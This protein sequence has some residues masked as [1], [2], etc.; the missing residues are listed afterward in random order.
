MTMHATLITLGDPERL[1]GGYLYHRRVAELAARF[2]ASLA[3]ATVPDG[4]LRSAAAARGTLRRAALLADVLVCDSIVAAPLSLAINGSG[5]PVVGML[6]Q[7]PGGIDGSGPRRLLQR[8]FDRAAYRRMVHLIVASEQLRRCLIE[9]GFPDDRITVAAPGCDPP[10][11]MGV[12]AVGDLR[13]GSRVAFLCVGNWIR[14]KGIAELLD[15]SALLPPDLGRLHLVG[16]DS[17]EPGYSRLVRRRVAKL[18]GRV[19]VH[20]PVSRARV[21]ALY[22]A[23]DV[24]VL[25]SYR[26]P[27][28]TVYGEAMAAGVP[29]IGWRAGNLPY[30]IEPGR[31]GFM[32]EPGDVTALAESMRRLALDD[33]LRA[34]MSA[35]ALQRG[36]SL[37]TWEETAETFF[38]ALRRARFTQ[39]GT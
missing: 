17:V 37:P 1:T 35:A 13:G 11:S 25:P 19:L 14:R 9:D 20:G 22:R 12:E 28:G 15:A 26:E 36:R 30:L 23:A 18:P 21:D 33:D 27:Y 5:V 34:K 6:H 4:A 2:D 16:D 7:E 29:V 39:D 24:F 31:E 8:P 32:D 38:S 10:S 3:F